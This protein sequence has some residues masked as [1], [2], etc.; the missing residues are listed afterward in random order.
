MNA[1]YP[2]SGRD[3]RLLH[4]LHDFAAKQE[5]Q[6][7]KNEQ[8]KLRKVNSKANQV[9]PLTATS[10]SSSSSSTSPGTTDQVANNTTEHGTV[11]QKDKSGPPILSL[12]TSATPTPTPTPTS[13]PLLS[14]PL[15]PSSSSPPPAV[16]TA[17]SS[18]VP[19]VVASTISGN[20]M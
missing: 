12:K 2:D 7:L 3:S 1:H 15:P 19:K 9:L 16:A 6:K 17:A 8:T 5:K 20:A 4:F 14:L 13:L 11:V 10:S 18:F